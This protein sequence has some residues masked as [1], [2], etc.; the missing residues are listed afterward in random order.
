[1]TGAELK[2]RSKPSPR[3]PS[4]AETDVRPQQ[5]AAQAE[6]PITPLRA[7]N[8]SWT[9]LIAYVATRRCTTSKIAESSRKEAGE[10]AGV[11][12][13]LNYAETSGI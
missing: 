4:P 10:M 13:I 2:A 8:S 9:M 5:K 6:Q 3:P 1:L 12:E 7:A 11:L